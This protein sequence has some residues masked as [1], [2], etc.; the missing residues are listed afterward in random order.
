MDEQ[1][2]SLHFHYFSNEILQNR[3]TIYFALGSLS[4]HQWNQHLSFTGSWNIL[5][6]GFQ[7]CESSL[8]I[9]FDFYTLSQFDRPLFMSFSSHQGFQGFDPVELCVVWERGAR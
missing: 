6:I 9:I 8:R 3:L 5:P 7:L 2:L 1:E 4:D